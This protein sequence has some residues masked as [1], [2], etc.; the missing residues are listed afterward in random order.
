MAALRRH[1]VVSAPPEPACCGA[2]FWQSNA[3]SARSSSQNERRFASLSWPYPLCRT[4]PATLP[5]TV[6]NLRDDRRG[7][8]THLATQ[9]LQPLF[10]FSAPFFLVEMSDVVR[11]IGKN[12]ICHCAG[13]LSRTMFERSAQFPSG[14]EHVLSHDNESK[15]ARSSWKGNPPCGACDFEWDWQA[16]L[17]LARK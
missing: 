4:M 16:P 1:V 5:P 12:E 15:A 11:L 3:F 7:N 2:V 14:F 10:D 6:L 8:Y 13:S 9:L 17:A